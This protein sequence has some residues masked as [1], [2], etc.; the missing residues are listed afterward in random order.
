MSLEETQDGVRASFL[1]ALRLAFGISLAWGV[2]WAIYYWLR[3]GWGPL[4][5]L[6]ATL[7]QIVWGF[8]LC[9]AFVLPRWFRQQ[10][11][12]MATRSKG[13][14]LR[15]LPSDVQRLSQSIPTPAV[16]VGLGCAGFA[17][18][19]I[20]AAIV[21]IAELVIGPKFPPL[22]LLSFGIALLPLGGA[23]FLPVFWWRR[24][25]R[26]LADRP[27]MDPPSADS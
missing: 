10:R 23:I 16:V 12:T 26:R 15:T 4:A 18:G 13:T 3:Y 27:P 25:S 24:R 6:G 11:R 21:L 7:V 1:R 19:D 22:R 8:F 5:I 2:G 20:M 14:P 17:A 9:C